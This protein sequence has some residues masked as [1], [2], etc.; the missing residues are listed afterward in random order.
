MY[1]VFLE[2]TRDVGGK[3]SRIAAGRVFGLR[4][5]LGSRLGP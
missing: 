2:G 5:E 1:V 3:E 4:V